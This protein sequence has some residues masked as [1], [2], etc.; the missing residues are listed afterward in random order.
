MNS[1][2][3]VLWEGKLNKVKVERVSSMMPSIIS[4]NCTLQ[5]FDYLMCEV[6][7]SRLTCSSDSIARR[8]RTLRASTKTKLH[9]K[10]DYLIMR[11]SSSRLTCS[12]DSIA[13]RCR[14]LRA[15]TQNK[16]AFVST[17]PARP[18]TMSLAI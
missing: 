11:V 4:S 18:A 10:L 6:S 8:C 7:S 17:S 9:C 14:T 1:R 3:I 15:S 13:R 16:A 12:S 2:A 5:V